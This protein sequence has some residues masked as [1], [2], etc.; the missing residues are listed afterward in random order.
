MSHR[1][2][3]GLARWFVDR[4]RLPSGVALSLLGAVL[5]AGAQQPPV[6]QQQQVPATQQQTPP[7]PAP[8]QPQQ[9]AAQAP[10]VDQTGGQTQL[11]QIVVNAPKP[12]T[13]PKPKP[14]AGAPQR[15]AQQTDAPT[16]AQAALDAKMS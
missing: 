14:G 3:S 16:A 15:V 1:S 13:K 6:P 11:P 5:G 7:A 2:L 8:A 12:K 4:I 9:P 10:A